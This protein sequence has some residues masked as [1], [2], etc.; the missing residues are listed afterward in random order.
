MTILKCGE[1]VVG[2][3]GGAICPTCNGTTFISDNEP[4]MD[5]NKSSE[6]AAPETVEATTADTSTT[7]ETPVNAAETADAGVQASAMATDSA[8]AAGEVNG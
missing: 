2:V 1:C 8:P 6:V 5:E 7:A 4:S 3:K